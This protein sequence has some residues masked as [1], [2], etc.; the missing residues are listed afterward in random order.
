MFLLRHVG[1][2]GLVII[3]KTFG[4]CGEL[5]LGGSSAPRSSHLLPPQSNGGEKQ[6]G[7]SEKIRGLR[8]SS[9]DTAKQ[10]LHHA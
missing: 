2:D 7:E 3:S 1:D 10:L 4:V 8:Y 6:K 5:T 9:V